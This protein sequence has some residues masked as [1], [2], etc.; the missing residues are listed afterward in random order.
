MEK[1]NKMGIH[2]PVIEVKT[3]EGAIETLNYLIKNYGS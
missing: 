1:V 2:A 3:F